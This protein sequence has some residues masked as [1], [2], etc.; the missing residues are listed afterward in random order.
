[1]TAG[2]G[3]RIRFDVSRLLKSGRN[4]LK[5]AP[6][7][8]K[9][10]LSLVA[11]FLLAVPLL[12][13]ANSEVLENLSEAVQGQFTR[14]I[15]APEHTDGPAEYLANY[16]IDTIP[17]DGAEDVSLETTTLTLWFDHDMSEFAEMANIPL[18]SEQITI[19]NDAVLDVEEGTWS[20]GLNYSYEFFNI[21]V[22]LSNPEAEHTIRFAAASSGAEN[23]EENAEEVEGFFS[24]S[25]TTGDSLAATEEGEEDRFARANAEDEAFLS[26]PH[27]LEA[28]E[29]SQET[30]AAYQGISPAAAT[31]TAEITK[32]LYT[33]LD[34]P[35]PDLTFTFLVERHSFLNAAGQ[36]G[37]LTNLPAI[38]TMDG[39]TG[40][41]QLNINTSNSTVTT[42]GTARILTRTVNLLEGITFA[43]PGTYIWRVSEVEGSSNTAVGRESVVYSD[44]EYELRVVVTGAGANTVVSVGIVEIIDGAATQGGTPLYAW[45]NNAQGQLGLGD[46]TNRNRPTRA[47]EADNWVD[48][49]TSPGGSIAINAEGELYVWGGPRNSARMGR[50]GLGGTGVISTPERLI[51]AGAAS[52]NWTAVDA[53]GLAGTPPNTSMFAINDAGEL[54]A[55]GSDMAGQLGLGRTPALAQVYTPERVGAGGALNN[56]EWA[57]VSTVSFGVNNLAGRRDFTLALTEEGHLYSWGANNEGQLGRGTANATRLSSPGRVVDAGDGNTEWEIVRAGTSGT[58]FAI[59]ANGHLYSWGNNADGRLGRVDVGTGN[60]AR[61]IPQRITIAN[62]NS[63]SAN[64][65]PVTGWADIIQQRENPITTIALSDDGRIFTFNPGTGT[66]N[67]AT[68]GL[69]RPANAAMPTNRLG[70]VGT[71]NNWEAIGGGNAHSLAMTDTGRLYSWGRNVEGQLGLGNFGTP[72]TLQAGSSFVMQTF[73]LEGISQTGSGTHSFALVRTDPMEFVNVYRVAEAVTADA[74]ITKSLRLPAGQ[75]TSDLSFDFVIER[76]SFDGD[77]SRANELPQLGTSVVNGAGR[78]SVAMDG[79]DTTSEVDGGIT[80]LTNS[81]S[82]LDGVEFTELGVYIWR[83]T[84]VAGSSGVT[85]PAHIAYSQAIHELRVEVTPWGGGG[86]GLRA[87]AGIIAIQDDA[88]AA[89]GNTH[90]N[91]GFAMFSWGNNAGGQLGHGDTVNRTSP[92][93]VGDGDNWTRASSFAGGSIATTTEGH[94]YVW[95]G[96]RNS[97]MM[98]RGGLGGTAPITSPERL[99]IPTAASDIWVDVDGGGSTTGQGGG[100]AAGY[101]AAINTAGEMWVW[102]FNP[103]GQLGLGNTTTQLTPQRV[104]GTHVWAQVNVVSMAAAAAGDHRSFVLAI[105][106]DGHLYS[107]GNNSFSQLGRTPGG[108]NPAANVPGRVNNP[109]GVPATFRWEMARPGGVGTAFGIGNDGQIYSWG[110]NADRGAAWGATVGILGRSGANTTVPTLTVANAPDS[111]ATHVSPPVTGWIDVVQQVNDPRVTVALSDCGRLFSWSGGTG[112]TVAGLGRPGG[113]AAPA[114]RTNRPVQIGTASNWVAIGGGNAHTLAANSRGELWAWGANAAGQLGVGN[115]TTP[116]AAS[117]PQLVIQ[118]EGLSGISQTGSGTHSMALFNL[119]VEE[120]LFTNV[121]SIMGP[122]MTRADLTKALRQ[123]EGQTTSNLSFAFEI[124]R[125]SFNGDTAQANQLPQL[126]TSVVNGNGRVAIAM[127][128]PDTEVSTAGGVST[129]TRSIDLLAGVEFDAPGVFVWRVSEVSGSSGATPPSQVTYSPAVYELTVIVT[130]AGAELDA[131]ATLQEIVADGGDAAGNPVI[132]LDL[133]SWGNNATGQLGLGDSGSATNRDIPYRIEVPANNW[134]SVAMGANGIF[135]IDS[136]GRLFGWGAPWNSAQMGRGGVQPPASQLSGTNIAVPTRIGTDTWAHVSSR[137]SS[138]LAINS[139]GYLFGWGT[140]VGGGTNVPA[141]IGDANNWVNVVTLNS[142]AFAINSQGHLYSWGANG[143]GQLGHGDTVARTIPTRVP[144]DQNWTR[145]TGNGGTSVLGVTTNGHLYSWGAN[146]AGQLGHGDTTSRD[147]PTRVGGDSDTTVWRFA[148]MTSESAAAAVSSAG[149]MFTWGS[150]SRGQ[151]GNGTSS[152]NV[153]SPT[154]I[155]EDKDWDFLTSGNSHFLA[156]SSDNELYSWGNNLSGQLGVGDTTDRNEPTFVLDTHNFSTA[157]QGGGTQS[158]MLMNLEA[159]NMIF[160]NT[161]VRTSILSASKTVVGELANLNQDFTFDIEFLP[162]AFCST[163][164]TL[165]ARVYQGPTFVRDEVFTLGD[166]RNVDLRHGQRLVFSAVP[167][168]VTWNVTERAHQSFTPSVVL[169]V[170]GSAVTV[171]PGAGPNVSLSTGDR[172]VGEGRNS[173]DFTNT[174][175]HVSITGLSIVGSGMWIVALAVVALVTAVITSRRILRG[176]LSVPVGTSQLNVVSKGTYMLKR[177]ERMLFRNI[178]K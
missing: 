72:P 38:G 127:N 56:H 81:T 165:A 78:A 142:T 132:G 168:G 93:Q 83:I 157:A 64:Q 119:R 138:A 133:Y 128:H 85:P 117:G 170:A 54:W 152:G 106:E 24:F 74:N 120:A 121:Q 52:D 108:A 58:A 150:G 174:H 11:V 53:A 155:A 10:A 177:A 91:R 143:S 103:S 149:E 171:P 68:E 15:V 13:V 75:T 9:V 18:L 154:R 50:D 26:P 4:F 172:I 89:T 3:K 111:P 141:Q 31:A 148:G 144:G 19:D 110:T 86:T 46:T 7:R 159:P 21:P 175:N 5:L 14:A 134:A 102:G 104:P 164:A 112:A 115:T 49:Q 51:I 98:G 178:G 107:W 97:A 169:Y 87:T 126:G 123:V 84:E 28:I 136:N 125:Y 12:T 176:E 63:A 34:A 16:L 130:G 66:G 101:M 62:L 22:M 67:A 88:G 166:T 30:T 57:S 129:L 25:F 95:G 151:L 114:T 140:G 17:A 79:P 99:T 42:S 59:G 173:A 73:G 45:G 60:P 23:T 55:W 96:P 94:L 33:P 69:G 167:Q 124:V 146:G 80:T 92:E 44:A 61:I 8:V 137:S 105:T 29:A 113:A 82:I 43:T 147:V 40:A 158:L 160:T 76:H 37:A 35:A 77:T 6:A 139:E 32:V 153:W 161:H 70:Q 116:G 1:M 122:S 2:N 39:N 71:A 163:G 48:V 145:I 131:R 65:T 41:I 47:G 135:A 156:F 118:T 20:S 100:V 109:A 162:S 36:A 27:I 90:A